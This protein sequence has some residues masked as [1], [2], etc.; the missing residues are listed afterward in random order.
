MALVR[1][2]LIPFLAVLGLLTALGW[3]SAALACASNSIAAGSTVQM[4]SCHRHS[5]APTKPQPIS[6]EGQI[7]STVCSGVLPPLLVVEAT[8]TPAFAPLAAHLEALSG[9]DP[10]LEPPPPRGA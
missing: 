7:C 5:A 9:F 6:H 10:G 8:Q 4:H 3:T 1:R 2:L